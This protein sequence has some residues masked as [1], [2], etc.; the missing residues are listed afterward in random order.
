M[1]R[2]SPLPPTGAFFTLRHGSL[3]HLDLTTRAWTPE[4]L[5]VSDERD[6]VPYRE[7]QAAVDALHGPLAQRQMAQVMTAVPGCQLRWAA[8]PQAKPTTLPPPLPRPAA[9]AY[10]SLTGYLRGTPEARQAIRTALTRQ[11]HPALAPMLAPPLGANPGLVGTAFDYAFRFLLEGLNPGLVAVRDGLI[12]RRAALDL[13]R[14]RTL[15]AVHA[16]EEKLQEVALGQPFEVRHAR[17][18]VLLASYEVVVRT[19]RFADLAGVVP[20]EA[21]QDVL[22]LIYAVPQG[23]FQAQSQLVLN[24][25]FPAAGRFGGADADVLLDD[26]LIEVKATRHLQLEGAYLQQLTGYLVLDRMGGTVG[27]AL[28]IRRL[29]VYY[30]RHG[31]LQVLPV[32]DLYRPGLLPQLV[33]WFDDSLPTA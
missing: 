3:V 21:A 32:K 2:R 31:V 12:A 27:S 19:G 22:A 17:A 30:A 33:S 26:L 24:P 5:R 15:A 20:Q 10:G 8:P 23:I 7:L 29:G 18:A 14:D 9:P 28:P 25:H 11:A 13:E 4:W 16:A 6:L 1:P